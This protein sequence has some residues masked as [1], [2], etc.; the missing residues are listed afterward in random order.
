[1][2]HFDENFVRDWKDRYSQKSSAN[3]SKSSSSAPAPAAARRGY[4]TS[5]R[6]TI[7]NGGVTEGCEVEPNAGEEPV[8]EAGPVLHL[9]EPGLHQRGQL[10]DFALGQVGQRRPGSVKGSP[11]GRHQAPLTGSGRLR[12]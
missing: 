5:V 6:L 7:F 2:L 11:K 8:E 1:M 9:L 3:A 10:A 12:Q 4:L